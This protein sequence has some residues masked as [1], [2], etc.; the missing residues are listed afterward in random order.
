[1]RAKYLVRNLENIKTFGNA[2]VFI[3]DISTDSRSVKS[4]GAFFAIRGSNTDGNKF[5][6]QAIARGAVMVVSEKAPTLPERKNLFWVQTDDVLEKLSQVANE[7]Y[8]NPSEKLKVIGITGTNGKTTLSYILERVLKRAGIKTG[9]IGTVNYRINGRKISAAAN[10]T[11]L[12]HSLQKLIRR[13]SR[14]KVKILI[15]EVSSHSL[16]LH[17]VDNVQFD[18]AAF[19]NLKRDHLDFHK[20]KAEYLRAKIKLFHLLGAS[21]KEPK[22]AAINSDD[23]ASVEIKAKCGKKITI[24]SYGLNL[25]ADFAAS[26]IQISPEKTLFTIRYPTGKIKIESYLLGLHNVYNILAAFAILY[27]MGVKSRVIARGIAGIKNIPGRLEKIAAQGFSIFVDY[28]HTDD[29]LKNVLENL[30][31]ITRKKI[32]TVFG[33]GG[34]RDRTK[35][36]PMGHVACSMSDT[37]IITDDNPRTEDPKRIFSDILKGI[38]GKFTNYR[39]ITPR[40]R[41]IYRAI[42]SAKQGD[43]VLIAGKG[44]ENYQILKS[45]RIHFDDREV[46]KKALRQLNTAPGRAANKKG[47]SK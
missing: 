16:A 46:A 17:R 18:A 13:M 34:D 10:T 7:F 25:E 39:I 32:I 6:E 27:A 35:R 31:R 40:E 37:V 9:V 20:S 15:M 42:K 12:A 33:C 11:P 14:E 36:G 41:A 44:H 28:A 21:I 2:N 3:K 8:R 1:M 24:F 19:T 43:I 38:K 45:G 30:R 5:I 4:G 26:D 23:A 22:I 29:A 47:R